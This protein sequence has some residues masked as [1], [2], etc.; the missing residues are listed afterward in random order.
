MFILRRR[1]YNGSSR[2]VV[3]NNNDNG[4]NETILMTIIMVLMITIL[5]TMKMITITTRVREV[6][7]WHLLNYPYDLQLALK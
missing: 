2:D 6:Y 5:M 1:R 4:I 3:V 7:C